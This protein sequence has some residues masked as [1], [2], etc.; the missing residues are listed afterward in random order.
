MV[1]SWVPLDSRKLGKLEAIAPLKKDHWGSLVVDTKAY[2]LA[3]SQIS[4]IGPMSLQKLKRHFGNLQKAWQ[5]QPEELKQVSGL[6]K[7]AIAEFV[8]KRSQIDPQE[9]LQQHQKT[10]PHF[11]TP[12]DK[13]YP[14][15]LLEIPDP[16]PILYYRGHPDWEENQG[17]KPMVGIVGTREPSEYGKRWTYR[18]S[19]LLAQHG[20]TIV[21]GMAKG[22]DTQAHQGCLDVNGRTYAVF[23]CGVDFIYPWENRQLYR[24]ILQQGLVLS[25]HP[26]QTK[27]HRLHFPK[28]NRIVAGLCRAILVMEA[29]QQSGALITARQAGEF[30]RD[31]YVLPGRIDDRNAQGC[32]RLIKNGADVIESEEDLLEMLSGIPGLQ[33]SR[34]PSPATSAATPSPP[35]T[36]TA[37]PTPN[38]APELQQVFDAIAPEETPFDLIVQKVGRSPSEVSSAL[39]QLEMLGLVSQLP[40][41]RYRR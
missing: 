41:M 34:Q 20:F 26:A 36:P 17:I 14:R 21:S 5:A 31:L 13:F 16:P 22:I 1:C 2:W 27:P 3:W 6:G 12:D 18:L 32:L 4:G 8:K 10:N 33:L 15:L 24:E 40:G 35:P 9:L 7:K 11:W 37:T 23:G 38:L 19:K 30:G 25:E 28:R 29:P 39:L